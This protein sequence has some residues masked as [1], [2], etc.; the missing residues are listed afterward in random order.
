MDRLTTVSLM[1]TSL[2]QVGDQLLSGARAGLVIRVPAALYGSYI[3]DYFWGAYAGQI[4]AI[5]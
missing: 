1:A 4:E 2:P 3:T 5:G